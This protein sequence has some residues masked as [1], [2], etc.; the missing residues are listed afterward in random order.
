MPRKGLIHRKTEQPTISHSL[1]DTGVADLV[2]S[3]SYH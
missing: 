2:F 3:Q 1:N